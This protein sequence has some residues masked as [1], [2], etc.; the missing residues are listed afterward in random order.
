[1]ARITIAFNTA[2]TDDLVL[3]DPD[4]W[5]RQGSV[6]TVIM[7]T[8]ADGNYKVYT[9]PVASMRFYEYSGKEGEFDDEGADAR[10]DTKHVAKRPKP[11]DT[12]N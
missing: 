5:E 4:G 9:I 8:D 12:V 7:P 10:L 2:D 11:D 1:M 3:D 6:F